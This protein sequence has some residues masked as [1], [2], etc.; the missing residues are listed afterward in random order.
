MTLSIHVL[1]LP[2]SQESNRTKKVE[3]DRKI[4]CKSKL[5]IDLDEEEF[6]ISLFSNLKKTYDILHMKKT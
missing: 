1:L 3:G 5:Y 2:H 6:M 4:K